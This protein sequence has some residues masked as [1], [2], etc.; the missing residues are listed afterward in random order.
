MRK[1]T[2]V[3]WK[4]WIIRLVVILAV[5]SLGYVLFRTSTFTITRY[6]LV[7]VP[8]A[9]QESIQEGLRGIA[10]TP[11]YKVIPSNRTFSYRKARITT[12]I[13]S[14]LPTTQSVSIKP[15][16]LHTLRIT[17]TE[18][19]PLYKIDEMH[20]VTKEGVVYREL[21]NVST[22]PLLVVASSTLRLGTNKGITENKLEGIAPESLE[23]ITTLIKKI[24]SI[25]FTVT[26]I[27]V[28]QNGDAIFFDSREKSG[29]KVSL[30]VRSNDVWSNLVSAID[31]EPLKSKLEHNK[32]DLEYLD[33]RFGNKV[34]YKFTTG[35]KPAIIPDTYATS[36]ATTTAR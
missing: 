32:D 16:S 9:Y 18:H 28:D 25:L 27:D 2:Y 30:R 20:A 36:T 15:I 11:L 19:T 12:L 22:L 34:F 23:E 6:E 29:I 33:T 4:K 10:S 8:D 7:G 26:K 5:F 1:R 17:V 24:D 31:T 13:A 21:H 14:T 3:L 35:E